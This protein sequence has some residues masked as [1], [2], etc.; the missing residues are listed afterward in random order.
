MFHT[1]YFAS[2]LVVLSFSA[3][4]FQ[5]SLDLLCIVD[6]WFAGI[7]TGVS[8]DFGKLMRIVLIVRWLIMRALK[9]III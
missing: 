2:F 4:Y 7:E 9:V 3:L 8:T 1:N 6:L 5:Q